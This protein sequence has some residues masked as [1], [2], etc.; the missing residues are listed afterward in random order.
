MKQIIPI[1]TKKDLGITNPIKIIEG[2]KK[3][4]KKISLATKVDDAFI[5]ML[6]DNQENVGKFIDLEIDPST[7]ILTL[8]FEKKNIELEKELAHEMR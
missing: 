5:Q 3:G 8:H 4:G 1:V 7:N 6:F 2:A